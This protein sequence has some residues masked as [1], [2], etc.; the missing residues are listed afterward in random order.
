MGDVIV[1][2]PARFN[3]PPGSGHGGYVAGA[4]AALRDGPT[5]V[6]LVRPPPLDRPLVARGDGDGAVELA[7]GDVV[8]ARA[9]STTPPG[10]APGPIDPGTAAEAS[11]AYPGFRDHAFPRCFGCGPDRVPGDGLRIFPGPVPGRGLVAACW[12]PDASLADPAGAVRP[13]FLWAALDCPSGWAAIA[14]GAPVPLL[15]GEL[16]VRIDA[17]VR[18]GEPC[19]IVAWAAGAEGRRRLAGAALF[20]EDR[21]L[22]AVA[23]ATWVA[24]AEG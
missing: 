6:R 18:E 13:E 16:A 5:R 10:E 9:A 24:P 2:I 21:G 14:A 19:V 23:R 8:V 11:R 3:G 4:L 1:V 20:G 15:L 7:D 22:R 12:T 17:P